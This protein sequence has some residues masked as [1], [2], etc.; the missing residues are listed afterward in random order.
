V[1]YD[2]VEDRLK[3]FKSMDEGDGF[4]PGY[5]AKTEAA[6]T[7]RLEDRRAAHLS[8]PVMWRKP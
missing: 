4:G 1:V 7:A 3:I 2:L 8:P 5:Q 6:G